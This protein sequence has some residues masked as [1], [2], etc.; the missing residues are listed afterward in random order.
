MAIRSKNSDITKQ[1]YIPL[2]STGNNS[3]LLYSSSNNWETTFLL[4]REVLTS[5]RSYYVNISTGSDSNDGLSSGSPFLTIQNA[6]NTACK[7][8][9][10]GNQIVINIADGDYTSQGTI[11]LQSYV[12]KEPITLLGNTTTPSSVVIYYITANNA[13]EWNI[14]GIK[15]NNSG[16]EVGITSRYNSI[17]NLYNINFGSCDTHVYASRF[18]KVQFFTPYTISGNASYH[19]D[20][21][22]SGMVICDSFSNTISGSKT[23][24]IFAYCVDGACIKSTGSTWSGATVSGQRYYSSTGAVIDTGGSGSNYFPGNSAGSTATGGIYV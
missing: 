4:V 18:G 6:I 22:F 14:K 11:Y 10:D 5:S 3:Q 23:F 19:F 1:N 2:P 17:L 16:A 12:G 20:I 24:T 8:D 9:N 7:L 13:G 21:S 15:L